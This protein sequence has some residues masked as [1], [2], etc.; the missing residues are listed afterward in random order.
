AV[1]PT[2]DEVVNC[3]RITGNEN[4]V[5]E[6]LLKDQFHLEKFID[7][8]IQFGETRTHIV[9]SD[10]VRNAPIGRAKN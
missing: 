7:R 2:F 6:V 9:L 8:L 5:M 4:I 3:Y 1:V 10:V